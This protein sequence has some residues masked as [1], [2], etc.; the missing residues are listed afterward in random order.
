MGDT[1]FNEREIEKKDG[2]S[3]YSKEGKPNWKGCMIPPPPGTPESISQPGGA[4][5]RMSS[6]EEKPA[7]GRGGGMLPL[8]IVVFM[9]E[10]QRAKE[11]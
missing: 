8:T 4:A 1:D 2:W 3:F 11:T 5:K 10:R 7:G 6:G 9:T